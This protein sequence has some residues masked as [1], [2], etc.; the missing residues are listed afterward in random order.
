[1]YPPVPSNVCGE[2]NQYTRANHWRAVLALGCVI[3][4][5]SEQ[6]GSGTYRINARGRWCVLPAD[7]QVLHPVRVDFARRL[8][9][10]GLE[11]RQEYDRLVLRLG[12]RLLAEIPHRLCCFAHVLD[13]AGAKVD[14]MDHEL[15][16]GD[17][18]LS[19]WRPGDEAR[20]G[21]FLQL[22]S[23]LP[24]QLQLRLGVYDPSANVR[25]PIWASTLPTA[26]EY[27]AVV[28]GLGEA[29]SLERGGAF[30]E[31]FS[32][33]CGIRFEQ[34]AE[35]QSYSVS[36]LDTAIWLCL[37][38][39]FRQPPGRHW[40]F[41]GHGITERSPGRPIL[42]SFDQALAPCWS[43]PIQTWEQNIVRRLRAAGP[44]PVEIAAGIF[45]LRSGRRLELLESVFPTDWGTRRVFLPVNSDQ[46]L[47]VE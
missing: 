45:D 24:R 10:T 23:A 14:S 11:F 30:S 47:G 15:L 20:E 5:D 6:M 3:I 41:F 26:G 34:G 29:P 2:T 18:P 31:P 27:T 44:D 19:E 9:L 8:E 36:R 38:W 7:L 12:W 4:P 37:R 43:P 33:P 16:G 25:W 21:L 28:F 42:V 13:A 46:P 39:A 40:R 22:P 35:L 32:Q 1:M 17:P